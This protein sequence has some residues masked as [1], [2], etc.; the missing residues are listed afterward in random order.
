MK[1]MDDAT[2][3]LARIELVMQQYDLTRETAT[4]VDDL[5]L[6][7]AD[8]MGETLLLA[9]GVAPNPTIQDAAMNHAMRIMAATMEVAIQANEMI[10]EMARDISSVTG[11]PMTAVMAALQQSKS[12]SASGPVRGDTCECPACVVRR[13]ALGPDPTADA[14]KAAMGDGGVRL[15]DIVKGLFGGRGKP[16]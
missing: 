9:V 1:F 8:K 3:R 11:Q 10:T 13:A 4:M 15:G 16:H 7:A 14:T 2:R 12:S 5:A 6:N